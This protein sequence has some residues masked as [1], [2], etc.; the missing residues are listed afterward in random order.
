[1]QPKQDDRTVAENHHAMQG[2]CTET[3]TTTVL[4]PFFRDH[5]GEPVQ[6]KTFW[7]LWCKERLT[8]ADAPTIRLGATLSELS[9]AHLHHP[10]EIKLGHNPQAMQWIKRTFLKAKIGKYREVVNRSLYNCVT[11]RLM[12]TIP[13]HQVTSWSIQP[14]GLN[15]STL[16]TNIQHRQWSHSIDRLTDSLSDRPY[17]SV[18]NNSPYV[19]TSYCDEAKIILTSGQNNLK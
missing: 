3:T 9:S 7:T 17:Y 6:E 1:M 18:S 19:C 10:P 8:E 4:W 11:E 16:Q 15:T 12:H 5:P 13:P 2:S 14:F